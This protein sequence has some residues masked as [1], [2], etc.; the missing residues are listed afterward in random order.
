MTDC[1]VGLGGP[2]LV[3]APPA[4]PDYELPDAPDRIGHPVRVLR[5]PQLT[6]VVV[7]HQ[8]DIGTSL[9]EVPPEGVVCRITT[10]DT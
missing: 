9:G 7:T 4:S 2:E 5:R 3:V 10:V 6:V 1:A 8:H